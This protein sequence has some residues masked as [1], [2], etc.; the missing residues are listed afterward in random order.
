MSK[1]ATIA[2][3]GF[4]QFLDELIEKY[5][6]GNRAEVARRLQVSLP[7]VL[8]MLKGQ[9]RPFTPARCQQFAETLHLSETDT[10]D[11]KRLAMIERTPK[12]ARP[13]LRRAFV[14]AGDLADSPHKGYVRVAVLASCPASE[15]RVSEDEVER[16]VELPKEDV[17]SR[18][19]YL[20]RIQGDS[21]NRTGIAD[22]DTVFVIAD[23]EPKN[24]DVV[25]ARIDGDECTCKRFFRTD[26]QVTLMPDSTNPK[27]GPMTFDRLDDVQLRGVVEA[28]WMKR[29]R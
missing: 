24:G 26:K 6:E 2:D 12:E 1:L 17:R 16:W 22:G 25:I 13:Y 19:V 21:M 29:L 4:G 14:G 15:K 3:M 18:R 5:A 8:R 23:A 27:H 9:T 7:Y 28:I 10:A 11:L 20:L